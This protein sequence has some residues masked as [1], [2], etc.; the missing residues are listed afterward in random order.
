[1]IAL[2]L[3]CGNDYRISTENITWINVDNGKAIVDKRLDI[4]EFP[5]DFSDNSIDR[6]DAIQVMEHIHRD[7]FIFVVKELYRI[8]KNDCEWNI[9]VPHGLSDNFI[10]DPTHRM[11]FSTRTF[12]YFIDGT[13]LRENGIIYGWEDIKLK[14]LEEPFIDGNQSINFKLKVVK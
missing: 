1:M 13:Q 6:I 5:Y 9:I 14:H 12:D 10:T 8:S 3:G 4:E 11:P 7:N 2:N